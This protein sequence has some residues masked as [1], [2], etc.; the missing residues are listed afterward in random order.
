MP[1]NVGIVV[2]KSSSCTN[3]FLS[4]GSKKSDPAPIDKPGPAAWSGD[5]L[6]G[7]EKRAA[8]RPE[9]LWRPAGEKEVK[10]RGS[11]LEE[12]KPSTSKLSQGD[13]APPSPRTLKAIEAAMAES[14]DEE[15]GNAGKKDGH[16]SPRT[17]LAIQEAL[18]EEE[19]GSSDQSRPLHSSPPKQQVT[20]LHPAPQVIVSSSEDEADPSSLTVLPAEPPN[21][22]KPLSQNIHVRDGLLISSSE[23]EMEEAIAQR[24][25]VLRATLLEEV[26][27]RK[28]KNKELGDGTRAGSGKQGELQTRAELNGDLARLRG[29]AAPTVRDLP[30]IPST[31]ICEKPLTA[32][33]GNGK[34]VPEPKTNQTSEMEDRDEVKSEVGEGSES[35]GTAVFDLFRITLNSIKH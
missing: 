27:E 7:I 30:L 17:M 20:V 35:E 34:V 33:T 15:M 23:D 19:D 32:E 21:V 29:E 28:A 9:P 5:F 13:A 6:S 12:S 25:K 24:N 10:V 16:V 8:G 26:E 31:Q 14:S 22:K 18:A 11:P 4:K 2:F 3:L 1:E